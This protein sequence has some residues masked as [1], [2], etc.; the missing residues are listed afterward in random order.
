MVHSPLQRA[1]LLSI[2]AAIITITLK[3]G[4]WKLTG[5]I[6]LFS[7]AIESLVNLAAAV[8][9][10]VL[11]GLA[12]LPA[13][14]NH[15]FGHEKAEYF[16]S[17]A[18]GMFILFAAIAISW[19]AIKSFLQPTP[20]GTLDIGMLLSLVATGVNGVA[21]WWLLRVAHREKSLAVEADA[22]HLLTDVWTS[23]GVL[24]ALGLLLIFPQ[25]HWIDPLIA[26]IVALNIVRTGISLMMRSIDGLMDVQLPAEEFS[27]I[28]NALKEI[29]PTLAS[30]QA[31]RTRRAGTRR[32]V[33]FNLLLPGHWQVNQ[34]HDLCDEL[35]N[36]VRAIYP[37][38]DIVIH[39][40]PADAHSALL[41]S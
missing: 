19:Q 10:F 36:A 33:E 5:S 6:G 4:A 11:L 29:M 3:F 41:S 21:A 39:V 27:A 9:G 15:P 35:E 2:V 13:D 26:L 28:E 1:M 7:D 23:I 14:D 17:G 16:S 30:I 40:E 25:A 18:E 20:V 37:D 32:F 22:Q 31:L 12:A 38:T 24:L 8:L 34:S